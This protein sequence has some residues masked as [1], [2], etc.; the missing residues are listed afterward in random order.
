MSEG[1]SSTSRPSERFLFP[2]GLRGVAAM[3]VVFYHFN[4][5]LAPAVSHWLPVGMS[6]IL[7]HGNLGVPIFFVLSLKRRACAA[8]RLTSNTPPIR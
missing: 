6:V 3:M 2:D 1:A 8:I 4:E 5:N 7:H